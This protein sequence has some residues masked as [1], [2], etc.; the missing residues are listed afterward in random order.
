MAFKQVAD[1]AADVTIS[2]GG[3]NKKLGKKNPTQVEGY[4]IGTKKVAD[5][6]KQSGFSS[7][8]ILQTP[9]G[10]VGVWGKTDM[11]RKM[12]GVT[13]GTMVRITHTG[14]QPT[15]NGDMYKYSVEFDVENTIE[16][17]ESFAPE[18][19]NEESEAQ[20][21]NFVSSEDLNEEDSNQDFALE[22]AAAAAERKARV[23]ALLTKKR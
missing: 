3:V 20:E 18:A 13:A 12:V 15:K 14:M 9:K 10:N 7:I 23:N 5:A 19:N 8:Y 4:F 2:L 22:A 6:K 1:L 16:V 21:D 11:D 17:A